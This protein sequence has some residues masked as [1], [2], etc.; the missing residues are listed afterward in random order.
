LSR[1]NLEY[2]IEH[3][4]PSFRHLV[5]NA[6]IFDAKGGKSNENL[7]SRGFNPSDLHISSFYSVFAKLISL[8]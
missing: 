5:N 3:H 1:N 6:A 8:T 4:S 2:E 7:F